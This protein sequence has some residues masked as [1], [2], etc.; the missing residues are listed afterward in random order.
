M[1][2]YLLTTSEVYVSPRIRYEGIRQKL[3]HEPCGILAGLIYLSA[4]F[5]RVEHMLVKRHTR[6]HK[7]SM[8]FS[9]NLFHFLPVCDA[10]SMLRIRNCI[11]ISATHFKSRMQTFTEQ[12]PS[13]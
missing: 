4:A 2:C 6:L 11:R 12:Q 3:A 8:L 9:M 5:L 1:L 13:L 10:S 7:T